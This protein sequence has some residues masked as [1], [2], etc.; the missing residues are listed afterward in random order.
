M[1]AAL[2]QLGSAVALADHAAFRSVEEVVATSSLKRPLYLEAAAYDETLLE[3]RADEAVYNIIEQRRLAGGPDETAASDKI[4][5]RVRESKVVSDT[6]PTKLFLTRMTT[7]I[8]VKA[9]PA[10]T[11]AAAAATAA[12]QHFLFSGN[13][14]TWVQ[15][16]ESAS[17]LKAALQATSPVS[18]ASQAFG[19]RVRAATRDR[20]AANLKAERALAAE[21]GLGWVSL[22][23]ACDVHSVAGAHAKALA[24]VSDFISLMVDL[25]LSLRLHGNM[26]RFRACL[27][28][29]IEP[30]EAS[31]QARRVVKRGQGL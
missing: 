2:D 4:V 22:Q 26:R 29:L 7:T 16:L 5:I 8:L 10:P 28:Q 24:F 23:S 17:A 15:T 31:D 11:A 9:T 25:S 6:A 19:M 30:C 1:L 13:P 18:R 27:K 12:D 14:V 21:R 3:V 20:L